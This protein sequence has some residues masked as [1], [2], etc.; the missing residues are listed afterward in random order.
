MFNVVVFIWVPTVRKKFLVPYIAP[1]L[2]IGFHVLLLTAKTTLSIVECFHKS[3]QVFLACFCL[4][5]HTFLKLPKTIH[6]KVE[7]S[8]VHLTKLLLQYRLSKR[9]S[10]YFDIDSTHQFLCEFVHSW[11]P[12]WTSMPISDHSSPL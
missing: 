10:I 1:F 5:S 4:H 12:H 2:W 9:I 11:A 3:T 6:S 8:Q 7:P